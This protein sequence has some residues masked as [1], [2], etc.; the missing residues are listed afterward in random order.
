MPCFNL[1]A[2]LNEILNWAEEYIPDCHNRRGHFKQ[3]AA[4]Y[5][6]KL[7]KVA[8]HISQKCDRKSQKAQK[9]N[10]I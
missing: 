3:L 10:R 2:K 5:K 6:R 4:I 7:D 1:I 8:D 9:N